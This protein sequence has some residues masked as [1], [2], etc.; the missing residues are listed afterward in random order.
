M[1]VEE[2]FELLITELKENP[3]LKGY[4]R[5]INDPSLY[6]YRKA[7]FCQR[8]QYIYSHIPENK[9][10]NIFDIGCGYGTTAIFLVLNGYKVTGGTLEYYYDQ[11]SAR[12]EYWSKI[13]D[14]SNLEIRYEDFYDN[15]LKEN[16]YDVIIAQDVLHHLEPIDKALNIIT[17][18]LVSGGLL[19]SCEENGNNLLNSVR[20]FMKRGNKRIIEYYDDKLNKTIRMGNENIRSL[21]EWNRILSSNQLAVDENTVQ[22]IRYYFPNKYK[23]LTVNEIIKKEQDIWKRNSTLKERFFHGLN[24]VAVKSN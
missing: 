1:T 21:K 5:F 22:Y 14:L 10:V 4:Y 2:F 7:Y 17:N 23:K 11:I 3:K 15:P 12:K 9:A 19:I 20:L 24:F 8:L 6:E 16:Y 18:S 13:G